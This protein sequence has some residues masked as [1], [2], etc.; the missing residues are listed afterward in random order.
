MRI[1]L[2]CLFL[3]LV[4][5]AQKF[6]ISLSAG[7]TPTQFLNRTKGMANTRSEAKITP[8]Y[9]IAGFKFKKAFAIGLTASIF[10]MRSVYDGGYSRFDEYYSEPTIGVNFII[11]A[12]LDHRKSRMIVGGLIGGIYN[13]APD[14]IIVKNRITYG[15]SYGGNIGLYFN[16]IYYI[17]RFGVGA[18]FSPRVN[19]FDGTRIASTAIALTAPVLI[20]AHLKL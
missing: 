2:L 18:E 17:R 12:K 14:N 19:I 13:K 6:D 7:A 3:P 10:N 20:G 16:Y 1:L 4:T 9:Q 15:N 8:M 5:S 11:G